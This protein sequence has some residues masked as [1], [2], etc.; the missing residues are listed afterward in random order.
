[1]IFQI[2]EKASCKGEFPNNW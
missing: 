1:M 2:S